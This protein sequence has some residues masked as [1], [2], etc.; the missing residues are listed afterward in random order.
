MLCS[1]VHAIVIY[2]PLRAKHVAKIRGV[3]R[4]SLACF[5]KISS[6]PEKSKGYYSE[7]YDYERNRE[8]QQSRNDKCYPK[9]DANPHQR[10]KYKPFCVVVHL[11]KSTPYIGGY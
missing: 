8:W 10:F 2:A 9:V 5:S 6:P 7:N 1:A 4:G 3:W 11:P